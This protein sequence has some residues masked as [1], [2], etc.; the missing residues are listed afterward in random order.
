MVT[1]KVNKRVNLAAAMEEVNLPTILR[2]ARGD[3]SFSDMARACSLPPMTIY[4]IETGS[5]ELPNRK[6]MTSLSRGYGIPMDFLARV[7]YC[8][9]KPL[10]LES[11]NDTPALQDSGAPPEST[12]WPS[13]RRL[14]KATASI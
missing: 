5:V 7:A 9:G 1:K 14:E 3:R 11:P 6:T 2:L 10:D 8:G 12:A 13:P 4:R